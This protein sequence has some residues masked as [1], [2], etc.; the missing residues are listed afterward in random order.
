MHLRT[1]FG[2][3]ISDPSQENIE[4]VIRDLLKFP[5]EDFALLAVSENGMFIQT[6]PTANDGS[7]FHLEYG[8]GNGTVY[9]IDDL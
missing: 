3:E 9:S 1:N 8:L 2:P 4:Q 5:E 7:R 6:V